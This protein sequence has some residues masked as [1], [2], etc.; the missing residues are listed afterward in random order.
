VARGAEQTD[1]FCEELRDDLDI[2]YTN[3]GTHT[4]RETEDTEVFWFTGHSL[5]NADPL[6][7]YIATD[8]SP[9]SLRRLRLARVADS[10]PLRSC[11]LPATG[12]PLLGAK[13]Y[14]GDPSLSG[15]SPDGGGGLPPEKGKRGQLIMAAERNKVALENGTYSSSGY[16]TNALGETLGAGQ[17]ARSARPG[18]TVV[19]LRVAKLAANLANYGGLVSLSEEEVASANLAEVE[20]NQDRRAARNFANDPATVAKLRAGRLKAKAAFAARLKREIAEEKDGGALAKRGTSA[21]ASAKA[22]VQTVLA[23]M[24]LKRASLVNVVKLA[25]LRKRSRPDAEAE[26][27]LKEAK[28]LSG[29]HVLRDPDEVRRTRE[30]MLLARKRKL[31]DFLPQA[32]GAGQKALDRSDELVA[33]ANARQE[34][35]LGGGRGGG[36]KKPLSAEE[37]EMLDLLKGFSSNSSSKFAAGSAGDASGPA[38]DLPLEKKKVRDHRKVEEIAAARMAFLKAGG[39]AAN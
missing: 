11:D 23:E 15:G 28:V 35:P 26:E 3:Q 17:A 34:Q 9:E 39:T 4:F 18:A 36:A 6:S 19:E 5:A 30:K 10:R 31:F 25:Q 22:L 12:N 13:M 7:A 14:G 1:Q 8:P 24:R 37:Q 33:E 16:G 32:K 29:T 27:A 38:T 21:A 20:A 2:K